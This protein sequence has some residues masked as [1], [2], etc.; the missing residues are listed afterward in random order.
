ML[1]AR[2]WLE[3]RKEVWVV[4]HT[5]GKLLKTVVEAASVQPPVVLELTLFFLSK[6]TFSLSLTSSR[7]SQV[8]TP[9]DVPTPTAHPQETTGGQNGP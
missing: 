8:C 3:R 2:V 1:R 5:L 7:H 9:N 4:Q 6:F